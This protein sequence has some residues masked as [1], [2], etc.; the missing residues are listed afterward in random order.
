MARYTTELYN[1]CSYYAKMPPT[2]Y[3]RCIAAA[4]PKIFDFDFPIFNEVYR[5]VLE[6]KILKH[7]YMKEIGC[8]TAGLWK[9][10]LDETLNRIMPYFNKMYEAATR[11]I[12]FMVT[13][14]MAET[15]K[16]TGNATSTGTNDGESLDTSSDTPQ[17]AVQ[18]LRDGKYLT[19]ANLSDSKNTTTTNSNTI[20]TT[21][22]FTQG[23]RGYAPGDL[24][25]K[26]YDSLVNIDQLVIDELETLFM[27]LW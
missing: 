26:Y 27:G 21:E 25:K 3:A 14:S 24:I 10:Q 5:T 12:D 15:A 19:T 20:N 9:M 1:I 22:N 17:G 6:T 4:I 13:D 7:F 16:G 8:E 2:P 11:Q 23:Y 18:N